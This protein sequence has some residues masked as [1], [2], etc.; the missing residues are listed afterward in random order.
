[1]KKTAAKILTIVF[2]V[3]LIHGLFVGFVSAI[4][5]TIDVDPESPTPKSTVNFTSEIEDQDVQEVRLLFQECNANT[6]ICHERRNL[7]MSEVSEGTYETSVTMEF[8]DTTYIQYSLNVKTSVGWTEYLGGTKK[9]LNT[10]QNSDNGT[11][12]FEFIIFISAAIFIISLIY[13][14]QR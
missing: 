2:G 9:D 11:P 13:K 10:Q 7:S 1:M 3:I 6:G 5:P 8:D 4:N 14:R 12:G